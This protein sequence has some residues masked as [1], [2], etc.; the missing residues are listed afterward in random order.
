MISHNW[1]DAGYVFRTTKTGRK[2]IAR[3]T[4]GGVDAHSER[5]IRVTGGALTPANLRPEPREPSAALCSATIHR[6]RSPGSLRQDGW[7]RCAPVVVRAPDASRPE[8]QPDRVQ[9]RKHVPALF[10]NARSFQRAG[11][12]PLRGDPFPCDMHSAACTLRRM[13]E[14]AAY[15][16][17]SCCR[18]SSSTGRSTAHTLSATMRW[19]AGLGWMPSSRLSE[20][21]PPTSS[22]TKGISSTSF[23]CASVG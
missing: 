16:T 12:R 19:P 18:R 22:N 2:R 21:T 3:D 10:Q 6:T 11:M 5:S 20:S 13:Q 15:D 7:G 23:F 8:G 1:Y 14:T 17:D 4:N 9:T